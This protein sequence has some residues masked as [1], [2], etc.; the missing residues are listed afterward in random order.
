MVN[1][2]PT[3][4]A[5]G[6]LWY[7]IPDVCG[8]LNKTNEIDDLPSYYVTNIANSHGY[9]GFPEGIREFINYVSCFARVSGSIS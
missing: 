3:T 9:V 5:Y 1:M 4:G 2:T 6:C 8:K 7:I